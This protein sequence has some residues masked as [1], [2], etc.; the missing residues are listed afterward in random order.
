MNKLAQSYGVRLT[1]RETQIA[2]LVAEGNTSKQIAEKLT[3]SE[4][5]VSN[6]RKNIMKKKGLKSV[7]EL[8]IQDIQGHLN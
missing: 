3:I 8:M 7:R 1:R 4:Y 5:T 6:H 2:T